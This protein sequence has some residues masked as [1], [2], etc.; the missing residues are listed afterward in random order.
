M[1]IR[2]SH[3]DE[4]LVVGALRSWKHPSIDF[5]KATCQAAVA[6]WLIPNVVSCTKTPHY[7]N[8]VLDKKM[9]A[10]NKE[11]PGCSFKQNGGFTLLYILPGGL[12]FSNSWCNSSESSRTNLSQTITLSN[13]VF[14]DE[15]QLKN[16]RL[17]TYFFFIF[18]PV[19][20]GCC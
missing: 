16:S 5:R 1:N 14:V 4:M 12:F 7:R 19:H 9:S 15:S 11:D 10:G 18:R 17:I 8:S 3:M 2:A 6:K 20:T 13:Q